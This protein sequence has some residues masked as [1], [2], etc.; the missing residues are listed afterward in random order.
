MKRMGRRE[1]RMKIE[2][3]KHRDKERRCIGLI[4][5][6][7][8]RRGLKNGREI[9]EGNTGRKRGYEGMKRT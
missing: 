4:R 7:E 8:R 6:R 2:E 9:E 1:H 3:L 5:T